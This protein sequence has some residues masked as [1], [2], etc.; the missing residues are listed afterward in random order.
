VDARGE[1]AE[2]EVGGMRMRESEK[3]SERRKAEMAHKTSQ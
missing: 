1:I 3:E 2:Q